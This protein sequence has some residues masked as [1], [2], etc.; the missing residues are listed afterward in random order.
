MKWKP[1]TALMTLCLCALFSCKKN[2]SSTANDP[3]KLK[4]YIEDLSQTPANEIDTFTVSYDGEN[5]ITALTGSKIKTVYT[6]GQ[7]SFTL[8]LYDL[9][10]LSIHE[11][12]YLNSQMYVDSTFQYDNT[13]DTTTEKYTYSGSMLTGLTTYDYT[14]AGG[15]QFYTQDQ[16]VYDNNGNV[17]TDTQTDQYG[18][19]TITTYTYGSQLMN[20]GIN[21]F[22]FARSEEHTS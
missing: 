17:T 13:N 6:Y 16:Y 15:A 18:N 14:A 19:L 10:T 11:I 1:L 12:F 8:D 5:R 7:S 22:Y 9:S 21:A 20:V 4:L 2:G 3:N